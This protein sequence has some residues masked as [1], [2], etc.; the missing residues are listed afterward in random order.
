[1]KSTS[2]CI[3]PRARRTTQLP[4]QRSNLAPSPEHRHHPLA[5]LGTHP[6][7]QVA[8]G[9]K[10][11]ESLLAQPR[12]AIVGSRHCTYYGREVA[13][14]LS[15]DL[16]S[17]GITILAGLTE[18]IEASAHHAA[19]TVRQATLAVTPGPPHHPYPVT[20]KH[21]HAQV[22]CR[23]CVVSGTQP[24]KTRPPRDPLQERNRLI[25]ELAQVVILVEATAGAAA[26][27]TA[28]TALDLNRDVV[29]VPGRITDESAR[30]PNQLIRDGATP[31]LDT[32]DVLDLLR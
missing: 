28:E 27:V 8:G 16:A 9:R 24:R 11:L 19:L 25:A 26:M 20:Q 22:L 6:N 17:A 15:R 2:N 14:R 32:N 18:G 31:V 21:L 30:G 13:G 3:P 7:L 1:M 5:S 29:A 4:R 23:G 12:V 10:R